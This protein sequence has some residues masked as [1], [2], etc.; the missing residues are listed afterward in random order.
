MSDERT[1]DMPVA[2]TISP[3]QRLTV[4]TAQGHVWQWHAKD[5]RWEMFVPVPFTGAAAE[6]DALLARRDAKPL[7]EPG[8]EPA[9]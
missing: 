7:E 8:Q 5:K 9:A 4:L 1:F 6:L 3:N 2:M